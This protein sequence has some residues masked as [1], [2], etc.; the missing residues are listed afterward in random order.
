MVKGKFYNCPHCPQTSSRQWNM[1]RHIERRHGKVQRPAPITNEPFARSTKALGFD[2]EMTPQ[3]AEAHS[4]KDHGSTPNSDQISGYWQEALQP[5]QEALQPWQKFADVIES[6]SKLKDRFSVSPSSVSQQ[7]ASFPFFFPFTFPPLDTNNQHSSG[8]TNIINQ[9]SQRS[10][11][12]ISSQE[13]LS[14]NNSFGYRPES[15]SE[16]PGFGTTLGYKGF[17]CEKCGYFQFLAVPSNIKE[18][19]FDVSHS[20]DSISIKP[21]R[22]SLNNGLNGDYL[23]KRRQELTLYL[24]YIVN[25]TTCYYP[26]FNLVAVEITDVALENGPLK[27][28]EYVRLDPIHNNQMW[29]YNATQSGNIF[30][31]SAQLAELLHNFLATF[32]ILGLEINGIYRYFFMYISNGL[33]PSEIAILNTIP[34]PTTQ[35]SRV[36]NSDCYRTVNVVKDVVEFVEFG[37]CTVIIP[38]LSLEEYFRL[39]YAL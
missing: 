2:S 4:K 23:I 30:I 17:F 33:K 8:T 34:R 14:S 29:L 16:I 21:Q 15:N 26:R 6:S 13:T 32:G 31:N 39:F 37:G 36:L 22:T 7:S 18:M 5:W 20:C 27:H 1:K 10:H 38:K 25:S 24:S 35:V 11:L 19:Y 3:N 28:V 9:P 12:P